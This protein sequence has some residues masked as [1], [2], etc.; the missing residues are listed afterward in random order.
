MDR[1]MEMTLEELD[2][3]V[4][5]KMDEYYAAKQQLQQAEQ[6][7]SLGAIGQWMPRSTRSRNCIE[8]C[9]HGFNFTKIKNLRKELL[10]VCA[11]PKRGPSP[12]AR[13]PAP[14]ICPTHH[15]G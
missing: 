7:H 9:L 15:K 6:V 14:W 13:P 11:L 5:D 12:N 10:H 2:K 3:A 1:L 8:V 4:D